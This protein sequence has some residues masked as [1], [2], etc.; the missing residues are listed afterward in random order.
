MSEVLEPK[1]MELGNSLAPL[2]NQ[3]RMA[4]LSGVDQEFLRD[5]EV[6]S[7][8]VT[9]AQFVI[10][11]NVLKGHANSACELCK[12]MDYDRGAMSRMIDR[13]ET[14]GLIRRVPLA[15]TRRTMALEVT[16]AGK[17]AFPKM[18]ACLTRVVNRLLKGVTKAQVREVERTLKRMLTNG[19]VDG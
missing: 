9:A 4:M 13:L 10:I 14:K 11:A 19:C 18:Q 6:A 12:Y 3:V 5:E 8:E 7:L 1:T 16:D 2:L 17:A 15:H